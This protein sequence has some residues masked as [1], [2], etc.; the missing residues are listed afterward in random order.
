M[1]GRRGG[2]GVSTPTLLFAVFA[3]TVSAGCVRLGFWQLS[4]LRE[5][6]E[7]NALVASRMERDPV[8]VRAL[9]SGTG[10]RYQRA[11]AEGRFDYAHEFVHATRSRQGSPGVHIL[12]PLVLNGDSAVLVNRG[13]IYSPDGMHANRE[14]W[15]EGESARVEG[16]VEE[17]VV[18]SA[19]VTIASAP[20]AFRQLDLDSL[21]ARVPYLLVPVILVQ[22][23]DSAK[24]MAG[25]V[26][27][28]LEPPP[29]TEGPHRAYAVQ[30]FGFALV[31]VAGTALVVVRDMR[32]RRRGI[33]GGQSR[34]VG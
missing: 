14:E 24:V 11:W 20:D 28:R 18:A 22:Q 29:L 8:P 27:A 4:R 19:P 26:P 17:F 12:T 25:E 6:Q 10:V 16:F 32:H 34:S 13:W 5:R 30:W 7:R 21:Q 2:L 9:A 23:G 33:P 15:R 3:L 31:G 1:A